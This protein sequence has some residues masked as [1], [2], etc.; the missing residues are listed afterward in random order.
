M[1]WHA[2]LTAAL[3]TA[4]VMACSPTHDWR[5]VRA[6]G[7]ALVALFP[8]RPD[9]QARNVAVTGREV[10]MQL[11]VC[12]AGGATYALSFM[13]VA[14]PANVTATLIELRSVA[15]ANLAGTELQAKAWGVSGMTPNPQAGLVSIGGKLPDGVAVQEHAGFFVKGLQVYQATVMGAALELADTEMFFAGL[16]LQ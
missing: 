2:T 3:A 5:E 9:R 11:L 4:G 7:S 6:E 14:D 16:K 1:T 12:K 10:R 15:R 8:C 13:N